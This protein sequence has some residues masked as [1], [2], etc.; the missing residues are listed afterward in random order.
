MAAQSTW[1]A[2]TPRCA[3]SGLQRDQQT[4]RNPDA[5]QRRRGQVR[6]P[7]SQ[8]ER[9]RGLRNQKHPD[10]HARPLSV[11]CPPPLGEA[12]RR[13]GQAASDTVGAFMVSTSHGVRRHGGLR[14]LAHATLLL[15]AAL[16][17][18]AALFVG[19]C[20][21]APA[22][23]TATT[24]AAATAL[25]AQATFTPLPTPGRAVAVRIQ[26]RTA[27]GQPLAGAVIALRATGPAP[28]TGPSA[29][30]AKTA[31]KE[32][33]A[34]TYDAA[35]VTF[36]AA[37]M[38]QLL[39][40]I[41]VGTAKQTVAV[42]VEVTCQGSGKAGGT[43]C[44]D[45]ACEP[46]L[47]CVNTACAEKRGSVGTPCVVA[48]DCDSALCTSGLCE[49]KPTCTDGKANGKETG[50]DCGG[51]T[52]SGCAACPVGQGCGIAADC[53]GGSCS[54][55][56]CVHPGALLGTG[57]NVTWTPIL[58]Q[59]L[60]NP[61]DLAFHP[62]VP[63]Q[64]WVTSQA[65]DALVVVLDTGKPSQ[66]FKKYIDGS[67]HFL[68][69]VV[70]ISFGDAGTFGTC[71]E[72]DNR[73]NGAGNPNEFMGPTMWPSALSDFD[74]Y[75]PNAASVHL[76]ML[77][78]TSYCMGIAAAGANTFYVFNGQKGTIDWYD[79]KI[80]H[81]HGTD[82][83]SDGLKRRYTGVDVVR[84]PGVLSDLVFDMA[85]KALYVADTGHGAIVRLFP[86][87]AKAGKS[88]TT[89]QNEKNMQLLD[90]TPWETAAH[91]A[92]GLVHP[93]GLLLHGGFLYVSDNATGKLHAFR[94]ATGAHV[95]ELDSGFGK[96]A[97]GGLAAGADGRLYLVHRTKGKV[98]RLDP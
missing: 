91:P 90:N 58:T 41:Q 28:E 63:D 34:G 39:V 87:Q 23:A 16:L 38:W 98:L 45:V 64:L 12:V 13:I 53:L 47:F 44:A 94:T 83:H 10:C 51:A 56:K 76:D 37:G 59:G 19:G 6:R 33:A 73:Y 29:P 61:G 97:L 18:G 95:N 77:H 7:P 80:P 5:V 70:A 4:P 26:A 62:T 30:V 52:D 74:T 96:G 35:A 42:A 15:R 84:V 27:A 32:A 81:P 20:A 50:T 48:A 60:K 78:N 85:T 54:A 9:R 8:G 36:P 68:E 31:T 17:A 49:A 82:D 86:E 21:T 3:S 71:G 92:A 24:A 2:P 14:W 65:D 72:S 89:W 25:T 43:C 66:S 55:S 88:I 11:H 79:F 46:G 67:H 57:G 1:P 93:S 69:E 22:T 75:G 40:D